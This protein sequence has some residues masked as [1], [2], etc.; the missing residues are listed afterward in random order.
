MRIPTYMRTY[1]H[2][3][4]QTYIHNTYTHMHISSEENT[5]QSMQLHSNTRGI[6]RTRWQNANN[7]AKSDYE[8]AT[9]GTTRIKS[10]GSWRPVSA[11]NVC[12]RFSAFSLRSKCNKK[13]WTFVIHYSVGISSSL[14]PQIYQIYLDHLIASRMN[15]LVSNLSEKMGK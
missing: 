1:I 4:I 13:K 8:K 12:Y 14:D 15:L 3:F 6:Q 2:A 10:T 11:K 9:R 7:R 5:N